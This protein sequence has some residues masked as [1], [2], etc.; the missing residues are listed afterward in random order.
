MAYGLALW[1]VELGINSQRARDSLFPEASSSP[2]VLLTL[3]AAVCANRAVL[4]FPDSPL[5]TH[6][7]GWA[8]MTAHMQLLVTE[9]YAAMAQG[10]A[11]LVAPNMPDPEALTREVE[12]LRREF[13]AAV[14]YMVAW[15][16][17]LDDRTAARH[18]LHLWSAITTLDE[19]EY[20]DR[21]PPVRVAQ[22]G[23]GLI[24]SAMETARPIQ[25]R[26][27]RPSDL[28]HSETG[29]S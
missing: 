29:A 28:T 23:L 9:A 7:P 17:S 14:P 5:A 15:R 1:M 2:L 20:F 16:L 11:N 12:R 25:S 18:H 8:M 13:E 22:S 19:M 26:S 6:L 10:G 3:L 21:F 24:M 27:L 4:Q